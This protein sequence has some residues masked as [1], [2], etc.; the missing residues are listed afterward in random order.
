MVKL[1]KRV[2]EAEFKKRVFELVGSE[3]IFLEKYKS[4]RDKIKVRHEICGYEYKIS[5]NNFFGSPNRRGNRCPKCNGGIKNKTTEIFK[6]ELYEKHGNEFSLIGE[7]RPNI[8]SVRHNKCGHEFEVYPSKILKK[9][10]CALCSKKYRKDTDFFKK[11]VKDKYGDSFTVIGEYT[12]ANDKI[13]VRHNVCGYKF[14][15]TPSAILSYGGCQN[16]AGNIK[17]TT[18]SFKGFV[19]SAVGE[20]YE[21]IGEYTNSHF[22]IKIK[23]MD[24]GFEYEV[25]PTNFKR[26]TR[27][28]NPECLSKRLGTDRQ[29]TNMIKERIRKSLGDD[30]VVLS[31]YLGQKKKIKIEHLSCGR[32]YFANPYN[33]IRGH[34]CV[35]CFGRIQRDHDWFIKRLMKVHG[36]KFSPIGTYTRAK[37]KI[38]VKHSDCGFVFNITPDALLNRQ[39]GCPKCNFSKGEDRVYTCLESIQ[40]IT[41]RQQ[42]RIDDCKHINTLRFDFSVFDEV[43]KMI[44]LIEYDGKQHYEPVEH[45]GGEKNFKIIQKRDQIKNTYCKESNIP[46]I[47]IP[48]WEFDNIEYILNK[49]LN[50]LKEK[51]G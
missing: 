17:G 50:N 3:Y 13:E 14:L 2:T 47:R 10:I 44:A 26:G 33:A 40:G 29:T 16:C 18:S 48:Y 51:I 25:T 45:F 7:Y 22:P 5:P 4:T 11:E 39:T 27:C 24:C 1:S 31:E 42:Y 21:V 6:N 19:K 28:I 38:Q 9:S 36:D 23:H 20:E 8:I 32:T 12:K 46:L 30:Y 35:H 37:E 34:G 49:E 41:F 15:S 43:G